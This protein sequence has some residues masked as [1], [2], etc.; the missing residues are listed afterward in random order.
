[1]STI[2]PGAAKR[3]RAASIPTA[4]DLA[5]PALASFVLPAIATFLLVRMVHN[6]AE[7]DMF[8]WAAVLGIIS[9][10][11]GAGGLILSTIYWATL[12]VRNPKLLDIS[13]PLGL[14]MLGIG[15]GL[16]FAPMPPAWFAAPEL[17]WEALAVL[18]LGV[19]LLVASV[20]S[21]R[22]RV[23]KLAEEAAFMNATPAVEGVV[24]NQG[25]ELLSPESSAL[26]TTVTYAFE[27]AAGTRRFVQRSTRIPVADPLVNGERVDVWFDRADPSNTKRIVIRRRDAARR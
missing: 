14:G 1:M 2:D 15:L 10:P 9:M 22:Q 23:A 17:R 3:E 4:R 12:G 20:F 21:T 27:D 6:M 7:Y 19:V 8:D 11:L 16:Q 18:A 26:I 24:T 5:L 13:A 25:Y